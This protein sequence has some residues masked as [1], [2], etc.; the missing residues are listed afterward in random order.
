MYMREKICGI[1]CIENILNKNKYI[2]LSKD[3]YT[4]WT[5]HKRMLRTKKHVNKHLQS[6]WDSYG[7]DNFIFYIILIYLKLTRQ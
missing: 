1:Y 4:R 3:V 5:K 2:G 7:E 6:A